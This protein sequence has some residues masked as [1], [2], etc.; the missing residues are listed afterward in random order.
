LKKFN[1]KENSLQPTTPLGPFLNQENGPAENRSVDEIRVQE[2]ALQCLMASS[3]RG[4]LG[5]FGFSTSLETTTGKTA[6][7]RKFGA[8]GG[9]VSKKLCSLP[10]KA[11]S[12]MALQVPQRSGLSLDLDCLSDRK[13]CKEPIF[14]LLSPRLPQCLQNWIERVVTVARRDL[15]AEK[16]IVRTQDLG[17]QGVCGSYFIQDGTQSLAVVKPL[18]EEPGGL[19]SPR[20]DLALSKLGVNPGTSGL[21]EVLA[22]R[23]VPDLIPPTVLMRLTSKKFIGEDLKDCSVQQYVENGGSVDSLKKQ[24]LDQVVP[25]LED[26]VFIDLWLANADRHR[27]NALLVGTQEQ[28][29][30]LVPIDHGCILPDNL[31]SEAMFFWYGLLASESG[32]SAKTIERIKNIDL[33]S[34]LETMDGLNLGAGAGNVLTLTTLFLKNYAHKMPMKELAMYYVATPESWAQSI[35]ILRSILELSAFY[36][37]AEINQEGFSFSPVSRKILEETLVEVVEFIEFQKSRALSQL[38]T[39]GVSKEILDVQNEEQKE[40]IHLVI[41]VVRK[42]LSEQITTVYNTTNKTSKQHSIEALKLGAWKGEAERQIQEALAC[43]VEEPS[44]APPF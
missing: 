23:L 24:N 10:L 13:V 20:S 18:N 4:E 39:R 29:T 8:E 25:F 28:I 42:L 22:H 6:G 3:H 27:G 19:F 5:V 1:F 14:S 37:G 41:D 21:R 9:H 26:M 43:S 7:P 40:K 44:R 32:F 2:T 34:A 35:A 17:F 31:S 38:L 36:C 33:D 16:E 15:D 12:K 30:G 11:R